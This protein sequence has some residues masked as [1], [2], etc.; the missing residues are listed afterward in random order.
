MK[1]LHPYHIVVHRAQWY[2][3]GL[4]TKA[5]EAVRIFSLSRISR[6]KI[7]KEGSPSQ[8]IFSLEDYIDPDMGIFMGGESFQ[9]QHPLQRQNCPYHPGTD[10]APKSGNPMP[11]RTGALS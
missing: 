9:A 5:R 3:I 1:I 8:R 4:K 11:K 6:P 2:V 7:L 10:L